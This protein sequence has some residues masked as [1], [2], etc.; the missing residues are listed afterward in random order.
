MNVENILSENL[1]QVQEV[2]AE[3]KEQ[4]MELPPRLE[5]DSSGD[6]QAPK[7]ERDAGETNETAGRNLRLGETV[8]ER[9]ARHALERAIAEG[10]E[11][12]AKH[13]LEDLEKAVKEAAK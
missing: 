4:S 3:H 5:R 12:A 10:N 11:I 7:L 6:V 8:E 2:P 9:A 1:E 13:R